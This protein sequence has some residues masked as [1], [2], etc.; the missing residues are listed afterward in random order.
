MATKTIPST[1]RPITVVANQPQIDQRQIIQE[2]REEIT[3]GRT[4]IRTQAVEVEKASSTISVDLLAAQEKYE[5]VLKKN[6][7]VYKLASLADENKA[8]TETR[9]TIFDKNLLSVHPDELKRQLFAIGFST[10]VLSSVYMLTNWLSTDQGDLLPLLHLVSNL[11]VWLTFVMTPQLIKQNYDYELKNKFNLG[12]QALFQSAQ[13]LLV[14]TRRSGYINASIYFSG[15]FV[16]LPMIPLLQSFPEMTLPILAISYVSNYLS[17]YLESKHWGIVRRKKKILEA[18]REFQEV[19][20]TKL[21]QDGLSDAELIYFYR[22]DKEFF[23]N[24]IVRIISEGGAKKVLDRIIDVENGFLVSSAFQ[25]LSPNEK[26]EICKLFLDKIYLNY[27][28]TYKGHFLFSAKK[29]Y[30]RELG[31]FE[32]YS[33]ELDEAISINH[34]VSGDPSETQFDYIQDVLGEIDK[35]LLDPSMS[36]DVKKS[37]WEK[38]IETYEKARK[39]AIKHHDTQSPKYNEVHMPIDEKKLKILYHW[40]AKYYHHNPNG[41]RD[42]MI[43][44]NGKLAEALQLNLQSID[45][46]RPDEES[47][48]PILFDEEGVLRL[49]P[50]SFDL[51]EPRLR[52]DPTWVGLESN[53]LFLDKDA[54]GLPQIA[55]IHAAGKK[56]QVLSLSQMQALIEQNQKS[57]EGAYT[58]E[59]IFRLRQSLIELSQKMTLAYANKIQSDVKLLEDPKFSN[60]RS[61]RKLRVIKSALQDFYDFDT[62]FEE[63]YQNTILERASILEI[64]LVGL[65]IEFWNRY[66][67]ELLDEFAEGLVHEEKAVRNTIQNLMDKILNLKEFD[68]VYFSVDERVK[69]RLKGLLAVEIN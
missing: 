20:G 22:Q 49:D 48:Q 27:S 11:G 68:E 46:S 51:S 52:H 50:E 32:V 39:T 66:G 5:N 57:L 26:K 42:W 59:E 14:K 47:Y 43:E 37:L 62:D 61:S 12:E 30:L 35:L 15:L 33:Q 54:D 16:I 7:D 69:D 13:D 45:L 65:G 6:G 24:V 55:V 41:E 1:P 63:D 56:I 21:N 40:L 4:T 25:F 2:P 18:D 38:A 64:N 17:I 34:A 60:L 3:V 31:E 58:P 67:I 23:K 29:C 44:L 10:S 53:D 28:K 9:K 8:T 19:I 36:L